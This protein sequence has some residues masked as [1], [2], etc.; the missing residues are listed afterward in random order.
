MLNLSEISKASKINLPA[1]PNNLFWIQAIC[2]E[3]KSRAFNFTSKAFDEILRSV[4]NNDVGLQFLVNPSSL[5][6]LQGVYY[7]LP[8][9]GR[10]AF[11]SFSVIKKIKRGSFNSFQNALSIISLILFLLY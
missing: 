5:S 6:F 7:G 3:D 1:S 4:F 10:K 11:V 9:G 2:C 8:L